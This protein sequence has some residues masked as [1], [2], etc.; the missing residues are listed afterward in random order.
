MIYFAIF[1]FEILL[2]V[3]LDE[4]ESTDGG[5]K[6]LLLSSFAMLLI[7]ILLGWIGCVVDIKND[8]ATDLVMV[9]LIFAG[10]FIFAVVILLVVIGVIDSSSDYHLLFLPCYFSIAF[11]MLYVT[12][13]DVRALSS[14]TKS[15]LNQNWNPLDEENEN[16]SHPLHSQQSPSFHQRSALPSSRDSIYSS[17][18]GKPQQI[19]QIISYVISSLLILLFTVLLASKLNDTERVE[20]L[21]V[22]TPVYALFAFVFISVAISIVIEEYCC[23]SSYCEDSDISN[24]SCFRVISR[25][26][27]TLWYLLPVV[28]FLTLLLDKLN[29]DSNR[30]FLLIFTPLLVFTLLTG[31]V[32]SVLAFGPCRSRR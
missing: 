2:A 15:G 9:N 5:E 6:Y 31:I 8:F 12:I 4:S 7:A 22:F 20:Y 14:Q 19:Y 13:R 3:Y 21:T 24:N 11:S 27:A 26:L 23:C 18:Q 16:A 1:V 17:F 10:M 30:S 25:F 28:I 29:E 32:N